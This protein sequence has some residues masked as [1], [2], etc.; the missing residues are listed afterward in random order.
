MS[1]RAT[2]G[3]VY[4]FIDIV[5]VTYAGLFLNSPFFER[6]ILVA[7]PSNQCS[8]RLWTRPS[9]CGSVPFAI[10]DASTAIDLL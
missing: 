6:K 9:Q 4:Y 7:V 8:K 10:V 1:D 3:Y 2:L 5:L